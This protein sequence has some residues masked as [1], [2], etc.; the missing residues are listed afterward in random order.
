MCAASGRDTGTPSERAQERGLVDKLPQGPSAPPFLAFVSYRMLPLFFPNASDC[1]SLESLGN[2]K[3]ADG[4]EADGTEAGR[5]TEREETRS[6]IGMPK[7]Y[8]SSILTI[9]FMICS[10]L[11]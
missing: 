11:R 9:C 4:K 5:P 7:S 1:R 10:I 6:A 8:G 3:E 2:G